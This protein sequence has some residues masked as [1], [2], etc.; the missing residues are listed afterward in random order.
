MFHHGQRVTISTNK[1]SSLYK[2]R[3]FFIVLTTEEVA[4][5]YHNGEPAVV[6]TDNLYHNHQL[7]KM[8][9]EER[10]A[11]Y[12]KGFR[13]KFYLLYYFVYRIFPIDPCRNE[14]VSNRLERID[15]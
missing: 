6:V 5:F 1:E 15:D 3:P 7:Q 14:N 11:E 10:V 9:V 13:S 4:K 8:S 12:R 2:D